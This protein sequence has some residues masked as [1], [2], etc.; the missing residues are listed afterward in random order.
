M[1]LPRMG[2]LPW[3]PCPFP[4]RALRRDISYQRVGLAAAASV[5]LPASIRAAISFSIGSNPAPPP[6][7]SAC[8]APAPAPPPAPSTCRPPTSAA[9][10]RGP[11]YDLP[12]DRFR[13]TH[14]LP[15][16]L[17]ARRP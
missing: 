7:P 6:A 8:L 4:V 3:C 1:P 12:H 11:A 15:R 16:H 14:R 2:V 13:R 10:I 5:A 17:P 9:S